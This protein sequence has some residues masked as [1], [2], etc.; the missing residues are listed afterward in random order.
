MNLGL[1]L[2][3][4]VAIPFVAAIS[5]VWFRGPNPTAR[6]VSLGA[7]VCALLLLIVVAKLAWNRSDERPLYWQTTIPAWRISAKEPPPRLTLSLKPQWAFAPALVAGIVFALSLAV[8]ISQHRFLQLQHGAIQAA[9]CGASHEAGLAAVSISTLAVVFSTGR[10]TPGLGFRWCVADAM[11]WIWIAGLLAE[12]PAYVPLLAVALRVGVF[13]FHTGLTTS[14]RASPDLGLPLAV[15]P[16]AVWAF[17]WVDIPPI[18]HSAWWTLFLSLAALAPATLASLERS[19]ASAAAYRIVSVLVWPML[20]PMPTPA[21]LAFCALGVA[22]SLGD[23][24]SVWRRTA[25]ASA[26]LIPTLHLVLTRGTLSIDEFLGWGV[27]TVSAGLIHLARPTTLFSSSEPNWIKEAA[28][29]IPVVL[30]WLTLVMAYLGSA[31]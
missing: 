28:A 23:V 19:A 6:Y 3:I 8:P 14:L 12:A 16:P 7:T 5:L 26:V 27:V 18:Y 11:L 30:A 1:L 31:T 17:R 10:S 9:V 24:S 4:S 13:P 15:L 25:S 2:A 20:F 22:S 29:A 21:S